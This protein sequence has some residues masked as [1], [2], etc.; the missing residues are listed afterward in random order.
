[1]M[2]AAVM[3]LKMRDRQAEGALGACSRQPAAALLIY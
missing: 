3:V 2:A 1:M